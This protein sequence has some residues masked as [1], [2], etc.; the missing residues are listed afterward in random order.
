MLKF[1]KIKFHNIIDLLTVNWMNFIQKTE[2][3]L[4]VSVVHL[5]KTV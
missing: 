3:S 4:K 5:H 1:N 2:G